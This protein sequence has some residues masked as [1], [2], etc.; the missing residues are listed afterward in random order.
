M[1]RTLQHPGLRGP[2]A[3]RLLLYCPSSLP[4]PVQLRRS[5]HPAGGGGCMVVLLLMALSA[6]HGLA[7]AAGYG[8]RS[9]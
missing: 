8:V 7:L 9:V 3:G 5:H 6:A 2:L 1:A 4:P